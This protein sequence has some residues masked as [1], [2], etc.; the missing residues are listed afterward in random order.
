MA[1]TAQRLLIV[2]LGAT[3]WHTD[4]ALGATEWHRGRR[5]PSCQE[6]ACHSTSP[7]GT[8]VA[9]SAPPSG[10]SLT[11]TTTHATV[12]CCGAML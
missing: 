1:R 12:T 8:Q 5:M 6:I 11:A 2:P 4:R 3:E 10:N 7:N 9:H